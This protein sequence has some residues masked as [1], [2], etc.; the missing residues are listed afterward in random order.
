MGGHIYFLLASYAERAG[1]NISC[2]DSGSK[3]KALVL[4]IAE[5]CTIPMLW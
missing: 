1:K 2:D 5:P 4:A 3:A